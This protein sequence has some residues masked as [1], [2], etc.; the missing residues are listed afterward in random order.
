MGV[1]MV[2]GS[3]LSTIVPSLAGFFQQQKEI[4]DAEH[5]L[6]LARITAEAELAKQGMISESRDT[7]AKLAAT[8][9]GFKQWSFLFLMLPIL[10]SVFFPTHALTMWSNL[11]VVPEWF[12]TLFAAIYLTIWGIPIA[13]GWL[14]GI[15]SGIGSS[16]G[17]GREIKQMKKLNDKA[18]Y[19]S[20]RSSF[21]GL[22]QTQVN[23]INK[24]I[25]AGSQGELE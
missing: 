12:R 13:Q 9:Q 8:T 18:F 3:I 5:Q 2:L 10:Y 24:A 7:R 11:N 17:V 23:A 21:G 6:E 22:T 20:L 1:L 15:F 4:A 16:F 19:A 14:G 25:D